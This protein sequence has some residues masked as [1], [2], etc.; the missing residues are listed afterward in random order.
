MD[1]DA[2]IVM[3]LTDSYFSFNPNAGMNDDGTFKQSWIINEERYNKLTDD[4]KALYSP[5]SLAY[6]LNERDD[7]GKMAYY[8][9]ADNDNLAEVYLY[10][11]KNNDIEYSLNYG[12]D[13][14][15]AGY[16]DIPE[17]IGDSWDDHSTHIAQ[18]ESFVPGK[19]EVTT[20]TT[21]VPTIKKY[22]ESVT[23][24]KG[25]E[26]ITFGAEDLEYKFALIAK[27]PK[28]NKDSF[29][30]P[31]DL[32]MIDKTHITLVG[33]KA[34]KPYKGQLKDAKEVLKTLA[35]PPK[36][37]FAEEG[38]A[39]REG[40]DG[41]VRETYF[42]AV[43][44]QE[45][46]QDYADMVCDALGIPNPE[47]DRFFHLSV[48]NNHGGN[49][50]KS[51]GDISE[52][53]LEGYRAEGDG[54]I[55]TFGEV[56]YGWSTDPEDITDEGGMD[57][58]VRDEIRHQLW[59][60]KDSGGRGVITEYDD[61]AEYEIDYGFQEHKFSGVNSAETFD[62]PN[63]AYAFSYGDGFQ[64]GQDGNTYRPS[65]N[66]KEKDTFR[67]AFRN[68]NRGMGAEGED[69]YY[70]VT[71]EVKDGEREYFHRSIYPASAK[72]MS[73]KELITEEWAD[74]NPED[75]DY[76]GFHWV[77]G[78]ILVRVYSKKSMDGEVKK[79]FNNYGLYAESFGAEMTR[80]RDSRGRLVPKQGVS[81]WG[82]DYWGSGVTYQE[83]KY[84]HP[85]SVRVFA[86]GYG[87]DIKNLNAEQKDW[88]KQR[89]ME[90][91]DSFTSLKGLVAEFKL[92][93][94]VSLN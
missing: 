28:L 25:A 4:D 63:D 40:N 41:E 54:T 10:D 21:D 68:K 64:D 66:S 33:G 42:A 36:P 48:A 87:V 30:V 53:D 47:P 93:S 65:P 90:D 3:I 59:Q 44:N 19:F 88:L 13:N 45:D 52:S 75:Y 76:K 32:S 23:K 6:S 29:D 69:T 73:D 9:E 92:P 80:P 91:V 94:K 22:I 5:L 43:A 74:E 1:E 24:E 31:S 46:F 84:K 78:E 82:S 57:K 70:L 89:Y 7:Q 61:D 8:I 86:D 27:Y 77:Y 11:P 49:S 83:W 12:P 85:A 58:K 15:M 26:T 67:E 79:M 37:S 62:A 17:S 51:V 71:F 55:M 34:L 18:Q 14:E 81:K 20:I 38:V 72:D 39:Y 60:G 56:E 2:E 50:F 35:D 16:Q